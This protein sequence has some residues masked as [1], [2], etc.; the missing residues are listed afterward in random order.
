MGGGTDVVSSPPDIKVSPSLVQHNAFT[1]LA[2]KG[3]KTEVRQQRATFPEKSV[4]KGKGR[5]GLIRQLR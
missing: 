5:G 4:G 3:L 2:A 1:H